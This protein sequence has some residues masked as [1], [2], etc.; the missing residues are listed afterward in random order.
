[1]GRTILVVDDESTSLKLVEFILKK[2]FNI[3]TAMNGKQ[4]IDVAKKQ[5]P[6]MILMDIMMPEMNGYEALE[7]L[8]ADKETK[9]IPV[10]ML[11]AKEK[12]EDVEHAMALG[13]RA[14]MVKPVAG[15]TA[16]VKKIEEILG[17]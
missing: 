17:F 1:M 16:L 2:K 3:L 4:A 15:N 13:A 11:T 5:K 12:M 8:Q 6:D 10:V 7:K 9:K 14:Y